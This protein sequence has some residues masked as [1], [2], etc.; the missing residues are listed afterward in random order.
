MDILKWWPGALLMKGVA[1]I[2]G[3]ASLD[4][5]V[6]SSAG[7]KQR[8]SLS[9]HIVQSEK[10]L[11]KQVQDINY[12]AQRHH[13][14]EIAYDKEKDLQKQIKKLQSYANTL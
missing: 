5:K 11:V 1:A 3:D 7:W 9:N 2:T 8:K 10:K 4:K 12:E 14:R 13:I 6:Q